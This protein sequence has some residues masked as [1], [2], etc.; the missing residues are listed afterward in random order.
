MILCYHGFCDVS[1]TLYNVN[2][3]LLLALSK[4]I[5]DV[6]PGLISRKFAELAEAVPIA[7]SVYV[8]ISFQKSL[9]T[10]RCIIS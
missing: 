9:N 7:L 10:L 6:H 2:V 1:A 4:Y 8:K 5:L 3:T